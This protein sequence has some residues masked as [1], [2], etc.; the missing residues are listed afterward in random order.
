MS[1]RASEQ[2]E[3]LSR[4]QPNRSISV[5]VLYHTRVN[6]YPVGIPFLVRKASNDTRPAPVQDDRSQNVFTVQ[7]YTFGLRT[8]YVVNPIPLCGVYLMLVQPSNQCSCSVFGRVV[9]V[10]RKPARK[11]Y[12]RVG[13]RESGA[14]VVQGHHKRTA[15]RVCTTRWFLIRNFTMM[16]PSISSNARTPT[17]SAWQDPSIW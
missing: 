4:V 12:T 17:C 16:L 9:G 7:A 8:S 6:P 13:K 14:S 11:A 2:F 10:D 15:R 3:D 1:R 5:R